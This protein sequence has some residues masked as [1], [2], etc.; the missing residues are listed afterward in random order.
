MTGSLQLKGEKYYIVLN[1]YDDFGKRHKKWIKTEF[2]K[3]SKI[4]EREQKLREVLTE[5]ETK[6]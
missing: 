5:Y 6:P 3:N 1:V 2:T 4:K